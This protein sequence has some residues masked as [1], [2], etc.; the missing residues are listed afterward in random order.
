[1]H[2][3]RRGFPSDHDGWYGRPRSA[4]SRLATNFARYALLPVSDMMRLSQLNS[5]NA[6]IATHDVLATVF[7]LFASSY[8]RFEGSEYFFDRVPLLL[9]ILPYF[10][11]FSVMVC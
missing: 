9:R 4:I 8:L 3:R 6:L 5:R 1:M 2:R 10:I 11:V 7:A